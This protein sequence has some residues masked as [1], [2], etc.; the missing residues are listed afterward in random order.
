MIGQ[1]KLTSGEFESNRLEL[2]SDIT[3]AVSATNYQHLTVGVLEQFLHVVHVQVAVLGDGKL[4][5]S[6][7]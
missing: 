3:N 5:H 7:P 2:A 6:S 1:V 4:G